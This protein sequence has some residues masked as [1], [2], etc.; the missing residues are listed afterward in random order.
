M[1]SFFPATLAGGW[2]QIWAV[3][4]GQGW[5]LETNGGGL[6][7]LQIRCCLLLVWWW[8]DL[9]DS[10]VGEFILSWNVLLVDSMIVRYGIRE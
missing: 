5:T 6:V 10:R 7:E 9:T 8:W 4:L 1:S 3:E 2:L